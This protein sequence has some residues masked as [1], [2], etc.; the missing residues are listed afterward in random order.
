MP[1]HARMHRPHITEEALALHAASPAIDLHADTLMW[2]RWVG[3]DLLTRHD[4]PLPRSAFAGQVDVPRLK[5]GGIGAQY[6]GLVSLPISPLGNRAVIDAQ[7]DQLDMACARAAATGYAFFKC[8]SAEDVERARAQGAVG[9]LLGIEG[10]HA[11]DG[12]LDAVDHFARRGVRYL[13]VLHFSKNAAGFPAF[14]WGRRDQD[15]LTAWG[16]ALIE[17]C[18]NAGVIVDLAHINRQGWLEACAMAKRPPYCTHTGV[19]GAFKHWRNVDDDQLRA[20]AEKGGAAGV[21]FMPRYLGGEGLSAVIKHLHHMI[22]IGGED[23]PALG[24]DWDGMIIPTRELQDASC[25]PALTTALIEAGFDERVI[26]KI[27]RD[28]ALRVLR[29]AAPRKPV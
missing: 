22:D 14:G 20:L 17:R 10:A 12:D 7:I 8:D 21:I 2:T 9:A 16:K 13:G 3:Y 11:L 28:N 15:G 25:M 29:D 1:S 27:L 26:R 5:E 24:S 23:L 6:F 4:A 18:E 19:A